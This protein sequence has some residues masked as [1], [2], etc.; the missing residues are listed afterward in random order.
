M[1]SLVSSPVLGFDLVRRPGGSDTAAVVAAALDLT[2]ADLPALAAA[3]PADRD[4][5]DAWAGVARAT[6]D[7]V[8]LRTLASRTRGTTGPATLA[9]LRGLET[10]QVGGLEDLLR[11]VRHDV[12]DWTWRTGNGLAV[13]DDASTRAV[14]AVCDA[15]A[16]SYAGSALS[17]ADRG[18][19]LEAW[20]RAAAHRSLPR[21]LGPGSASVHRLLFR[22]RT[23]L[24]A[25][26]DA[27]RA[28]ADQYRRTSGASTGTSSWALAVHNASWAAHLSD[29]T[30]V[31]AQAQMLAVMTT[32]AAG[33]GTSDCA[34]GVW[35]LVSGAV[36][37]LVVADLLADA[38]VDALVEPLAGV[39]GPLR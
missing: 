1:Y 13:Q 28:A 35:N 10:T 23:C 2:A 4:R 14:A 8:D 30:R 18:V 22:V 17:T 11:C 31:A 3:A 19:L 25:D 37:A 34:G 29:R 7:S 16:A 33:F 21:D 20:R 32:Q 26:R 27:V 15:V 39:L 9:A 12:F 36:H 38:D 24:P 6:R 5:A